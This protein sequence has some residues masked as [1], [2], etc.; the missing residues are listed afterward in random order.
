MDSRSSHA[1]VIK[2]IITQVSSTSVHLGHFEGHAISSAQVKVLRDVADQLERAEARNAAE[3]LLPTDTDID[4]EDIRTRIATLT[5]Q[6]KGK[7]VT[8]TFAD[9]TQKPIINLGINTLL[10]ERAHLRKLLEKFGA[11]DIS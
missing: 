7:Q 2:N 3:G 4:E 11:L 1:H 10:S 6:I 8:I 5:S 9:K